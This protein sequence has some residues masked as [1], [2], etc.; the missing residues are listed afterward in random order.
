MAVKLVVCAGRQACMHACSFITQS[1]SSIAVRAVG[2]TRRT[3]FAEKNAPAIDYLGVLCPF[4][5]RG[6]SGC[7]KSEA[8]CMSLLVGIRNSNWRVI[9][10]TKK[11]SL[12]LLL[13]TIADNHTQRCTHVACAQR[14]TVSNSACLM[15]RVFKQCKI[16]HVE[17]QNNYPH[18]WSGVGIYL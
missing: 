5:F 17:C 4:H 3:L 8:M 7:R 1:A 2:L 6:H 13:I 16:R 14:N 12:N 11:P 10:C 15:V 9:L 18:P